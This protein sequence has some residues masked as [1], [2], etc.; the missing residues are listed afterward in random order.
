MKD[1]SEILCCFLMFLT[2]LFYKNITVLLTHNYCYIGITEFFMMSFS[3][4][5]QRVG[6][7]VKLCEIEWF[8]LE[9][10]DGYINLMLCV[11]KYSFMCWCGIFICFFLFLL[12]FEISFEREYRSSLQISTP[13]MSVCLYCRIWHDLSC[14]MKFY[15][16]CVR[17]CYKASLWFPFEH[18]CEQVS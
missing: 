8:Y 11:W 9:N 18:F 5:L 16:A 6:V 15:E 13:N 4:V 17:K 12:Y 3:F 14:N 7:S 2:W 10:L 1:R